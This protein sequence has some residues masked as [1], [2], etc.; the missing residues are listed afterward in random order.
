M[1]LADREFLKKPHRMPLCGFAGKA[2]RND[3]THLRCASASGKEVLEKVVVKE[4]KDVNAD[5]RI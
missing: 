4:D 2:R 1:L 5:G 3:A